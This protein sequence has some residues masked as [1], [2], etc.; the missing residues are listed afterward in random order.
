MASHWRGW[1][2]RSKSAKPATFEFSESCNAGSK[3]RNA[4]RAALATM[5]LAS[6][7]KAVLLRHLGAL[8]DGLEWLHKLRPLCDP[9]STASLHTVAEGALLDAE[10]RRASLDHITRPNIL[11][12]V[13][14]CLPWVPREE[15]QHSLAAL[16]ELIWRLP[17]PM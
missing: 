12:F 16:A 7:D 9:L 8:T 14:G 11:L 17:P 6:G 4:I 5:S 3:L 13:Q 10:T 1:N 15:S 2:E